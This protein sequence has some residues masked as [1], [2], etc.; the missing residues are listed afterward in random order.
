M[1]ITGILVKKLSERE[2]VSKTTG[3]PWKNAEFLVELPGQYPRHVNF[4]VKDG[5]V[6][7]IS[8]FDSLIGKMVT[9]TFN[10]DAREYNGRWYNDIEA[11]GIVEYI[12]Q[13]TRQANIAAAQSQQTQQADGEKKDDLPF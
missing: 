11:Y 2:G 13:T 8:H 7:R 10:I 1:E 9:L 4:T 3:N 12:D 6:G 5:Q